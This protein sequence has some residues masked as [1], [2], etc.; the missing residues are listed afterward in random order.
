MKKIESDIIVLQKAVQ[1]YYKKVKSKN[2]GTKKEIDN[3]PLFLLC[4]G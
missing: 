4:A 2:A 1:R 3:Q